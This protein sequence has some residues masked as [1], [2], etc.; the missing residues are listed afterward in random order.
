MAAYVP[1]DCPTREKHSWTGDASV[2][3]E[4]AMYNLFAPHVF[5]QFLDTVRASQGKD[6]NVA[7]A[8]PQ[9]SGAQG[10]PSDIS[11]SAGYP[12]VAN[13]LLLYY[14]DTAVVRDH[15]PALKAYVDG[16]VAQ[17]P[18]AANQSAVPSFF[19]CGDWCAIEPRT[20]E[21]AGTGPPAAAANYILAVQAMTQMAAAIGE[22]ADAAR[23]GAQ[24]AGWKALFHAAHWHANTSS[25]TGTQLEVQAIS[26]IALGADAVPPALREQV[27]RAGMVDDIVARGY[28][29]TIGSTGAKWLLRE[30][31]ANGQHDA[32]LRLAAQTS[33]PSFGW[34]LAQG[35]TTCWE[36][37]SGVEDGSHP[38]S[39]QGPP[40]W[41]GG[42]PNNPTH[43]H[44]FLCG[45]L[46]E[47]QYRS[48]GGIAP[49]SAGY[50]N[51]SIAP[52][53]SRTLGPSSVAAS[54]QTVRGLVASNWTRLDGD[55][56]SCFVELSVSVPVGM[57]AMIALPLLGRAADNVTVGEASF[58]RVWN[59]G[60][61]F[62][63]R[64][65]WMV[66]AAPRVSK[67]GDALLF[68]SAAGEFTL[69][70]CNTN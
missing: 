69:R 43:N 27:V 42:G 31:S 52:Q 44:I 48:L 24:L 46:G 21:I 58:G 4:E 29:H 19:S 23:Y 64:P 6:G 38:G 68:D 7:M 56:S 25:Y 8:V 61:P 10:K 16:Q 18:G 67:G 49:A 2:T 35:A 63:A 28:H 5:E 33:Y 3:A 12:Q 57:R 54:V 13:W 11:W 30:L 59:A 26:A 50:A 45:G 15:W 22:S 62:A 47:W 41:G 40:L 65:L 55:G 60:A 9:K 20:L 17:T 36:S 51:V 70:A 37:W 53:I 66:H 34:W 32:A 14:G 39:P 1:T